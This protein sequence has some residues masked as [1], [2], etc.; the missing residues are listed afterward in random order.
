MNIKIYPENVWIK[1]KMTY[2]GRDYVIDDGSDYFLNQ[3]H[4]LLNSK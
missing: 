2:N 4:K 1:Y 3:I